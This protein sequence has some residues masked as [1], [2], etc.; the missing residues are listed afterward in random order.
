MSDH[1][2]IDINQDRLC[3]PADRIVLNA[4]RQLKLYKKPLSNGQYAIGLFN[5]A[6][7]IQDISFSIKQLNI[8]GK[9]KIRD[10]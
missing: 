4:E 8:D 6:G 10:V 5:V 7:K 3:K 2:V 1:E 9:W